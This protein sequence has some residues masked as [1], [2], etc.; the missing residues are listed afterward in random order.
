MN[1]FKNK[2]L[3]LVLVLCLVF[4]VFIGITANRNENSG[5]FQQLVTGAVSPLQRIV[6]VA[7]QRVSNMFYYVSSIAT[8]RKENIE[9]KSEIQNLNSKLVDFDRYKKENIELSSLL[10]FKNSNA[11]LTYISATVVG[12]IGENWF[13]ELMLDVGTK[14]GVK[15]GEYVVNGQGMIGEVQEV[16]QNSCKV[17][18]ILD[19]KANIPGKISS[20]G[21]TGL[22]T[23]SEYVSTNKSCKINY[24]PPDT[25]TK[26]G[27]LVVTSNIITYGNDLVQENLLIGTVTSVEEEKTNLIEAAYIKPAVDFSKLEKVMV[28][29]K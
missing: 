27:D 5:L 13:N 28:I 10:H 8:T 25:K 26:A 9:L 11:N 4:T 14:Q 20:T 16:N 19:D 12:K 1:F 3:T 2:L 18:T 24:L 17:V 29:Q 6:Y 22:I 23:G 15:K 7:G 21:E